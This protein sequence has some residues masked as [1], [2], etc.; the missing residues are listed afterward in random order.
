MGCEF[1]CF[2]PSMKP[3]QVLLLARL[4]KSQRSVWL[5]LSRS[6]ESSQLSS[7]GGELVTWCRELGDFPLPAYACLHVYYWKSQGEEK[8]SQGTRCGQE[9]GS[10]CP[11]KGGAGSLAEIK[12]GGIAAPSAWLSQRGFQG[13]PGRRVKEQGA[14]RLQGP[15][16]CP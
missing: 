9:P 3:L 6:E 14:A 1:F 4:S 2:H 13:Q 11:R 7:K 10:E 5:S 15:P 16:G 8:S 12:A